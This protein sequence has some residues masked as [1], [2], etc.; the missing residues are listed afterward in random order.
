MRELRASKAY[1]IEYGSVR[2]SVFAI[3]KSLKINERFLK[4]TEN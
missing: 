1:R 2:N 3:R 4:D